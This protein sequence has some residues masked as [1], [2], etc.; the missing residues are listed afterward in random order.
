MRKTIHKWFWAWDFDKEEK[1]LCEMAAKGL[2]LTGVGFCRYEFETTLPGEYRIRMQLM[3]HMPC[4]P[5]SESYI[6]FVE[7]TGAQ[8]VGS[9]LRWVYFRKKAEDGNFELFSDNGSRIS[10]LT[11][12]ISFLVALVVANLLIGIGN[13]SIALSS[14]SDINDINYIGIINIIIAILGTMGILRLIA[15]KRRLKKEMEICE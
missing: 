11:M 14:K 12:I 2:A 5:E 1:W 3:K 7:D 15:K 6:A 4:H 9:F 8:Q 10:Q 13:V